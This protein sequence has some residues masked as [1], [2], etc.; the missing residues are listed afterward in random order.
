MNEG[1]IM[2]NKELIE[3]FERYEKTLVG[4]LSRYEDYQIRRDDDTIL[5]QTVNELI[6]LFNDALGNNRYTDQIVNEFNAGTANEFRSPSFKSLEN[7]ISV[8][9]AALTRFKRDPGLLDRKKIQE[10]LAHRENIF[11][12]HGKD[13]AKW[14]ELKDILQSEL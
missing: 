6:D 12:I 14:R 11:I 13:E 9:R 10:N 4:I 5:R 7:I 3:E 1:N 2:N 8:T